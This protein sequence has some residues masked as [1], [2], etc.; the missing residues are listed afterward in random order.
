MTD[1]QN[2]TLHISIAS[3][4]TGDMKGVSDWD[5]SLNMQ[6]LHDSQLKS[7]IVLHKVV[8]VCISEPFKA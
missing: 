1:M 5:H 3:S 8:A 4:N 6:A 2:F 7:E